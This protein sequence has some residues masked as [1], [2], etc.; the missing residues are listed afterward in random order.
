MGLKYMHDKMIPHRNLKS[1]NLFLTASGGIRVGDYGISKVLER[2]LASASTNV[3]AVQYLSP[4][5]CQDGAQSFKGDVWALGCILHEM[6]ALRLPFDEPSVTGLVLKI[7]RGPTP[8][9][10]KQYSGE[11]RKIC[12]SLL[13]REGEKRPS[14]MEVLQLALLQQEIRRM[15]NEEPAQALSATPRAPMLAK[16]QPS[17]GNSNVVLPRLL[18]PKG[19]GSFFR[20]GSSIGEKSSST[21]GRDFKLS[22]R[23][24]GITTSWYG[25]QTALEDS[26]RT[27]G[28]V[29]GTDTVPDGAPLS[30]ATRSDGFDADK[31]VNGLL[32]DATK[33][34]SPRAVPAD[35]SGL[36]SGETDDSEAIRSQ[37]PPMHSREFPD[38]PLFN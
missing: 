23:Q 34:Q 6:A 24:R 21:P 7:I 19:G 13:Q 10:P 20:R 8:Q 9:F 5:I 25:S 29:P 30:S 11:L 12:S 1:R 37:M 18:A 16:L 26:T 27:L 35:H 28:P 38:F 14:T 33:A 15:L 31:F 3:K 2:S 36:M 17:P 4:E 22:E 32:S